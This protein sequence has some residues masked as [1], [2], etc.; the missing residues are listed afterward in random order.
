MALCE[1][2]ESLKFQMDWIWTSSGSFVASAT[3]GSELDGVQ[4]D[5][6]LES[7]YVG[8]WLLVEKR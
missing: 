1:S 8:A 5:V 6:L 3:S 2:E 4:T 7:P